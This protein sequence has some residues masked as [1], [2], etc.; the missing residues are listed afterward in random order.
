MYAPQAFTDLQLS[1]RRTMEDTLA[2]LE[3]DE[4]GL[5]VG[6]PTVAEEIQDTLAIGLS[7]ALFPPLRAG[8][9]CTLALPGAGKCLHPGCT[10]TNCVG[11][12]V[13]TEN[14]D[15]EQPPYATSLS[16]YHFKSK[17]CLAYMPMHIYV[18]LLCY[19]WP[20]V[21]TT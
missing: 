7:G 13:L 20:Y 15:H 8:A 12:V 3:A 1:V 11:N 19:L 2:A 5:L 14:G 10:L 4:D 9:V 21:H 18:V 6:D 17:S 16:F